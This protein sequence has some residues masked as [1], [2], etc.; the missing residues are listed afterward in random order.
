MFKRFIAAAL[1]TTTVSLPAYAGEFKLMSADIQNGKFMSKDHEF[2]GFGCEGK[3][4]SPQLSWSNAPKGTKSFA[5]T[6]YDPDAPTGSGWWHWQ[7][8][9]LP[10]TVTSI[11]TGS[12]NLPSQALQIENDYGSAAFGG[13]CPPAGHG[14][15]RYQFKVHALSV[16][17]LDLSS[18]VSGALVG[19]MINANTIES[20]SIESFYER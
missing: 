12:P 15:H 14:K 7:L 13:A 20:A 6:V 3:N 9:N 19:Y 17:K 1:L 16:E 8:I 10:T 18:K 5:I 2:V 4:L 11:E